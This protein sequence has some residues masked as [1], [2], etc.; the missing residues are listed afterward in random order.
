[1][2]LVLHLLEYRHTEEL[3]LF[4]GG[5]CIQIPYGILRLAFGETSC[6]K[7]MGVA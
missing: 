3:G 4:L 7:C 2:L 5:G 6:K 1:M